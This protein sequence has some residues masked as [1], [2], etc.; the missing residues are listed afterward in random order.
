MPFQVR[1]CFSLPLA[2]NP[3]KPIM[4]PTELIMQYERILGEPGSPKR[5]VLLLT[6]GGSVVVST[7]ASRR[8]SGFAPRTRRISRLCKNLALYIRD[9]VPLCLSDETLKYVGP[10]KF[11]LDL[12]LKFRKYP[13][14]ICD[15][16]TKGLQKSPQS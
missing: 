9:C 14:I 13:A 2:G 15:Q 8:R 7:S 6:M 11:Y 4:N 16:T 10:F 3:T 5:D 12:K 1:P